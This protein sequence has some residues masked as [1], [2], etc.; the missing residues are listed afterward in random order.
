MLSDCTLFCAQM[1]AE[2]GA[3]F[4]V[5]D[6]VVSEV[7]RECGIA[8]AYYSAVIMAIRRVT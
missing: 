2:L 3:E 1:A 4:L 8:S 5:F 7:M 6:R